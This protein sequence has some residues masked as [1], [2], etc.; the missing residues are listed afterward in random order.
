MRNMNKTGMRNL[1]LLALLLL[2]VG[3]CADVSNV[4][5]C[6]LEGEHTYGFWGGLW[7][8]M[9]AGIAFFG[10]IFSDDIAMYAVNNS[11]GWY[12]FGYFLGIGSL[13]GGLTNIVWRKK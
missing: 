1:L 9:T 7:H 3:G 2:I 12:D 11:G 8:G 13:G 5:L 6:L 4:E 10:Q